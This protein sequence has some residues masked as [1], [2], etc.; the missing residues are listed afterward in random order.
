MVTLLDVG[1]FVPAMSVLENQ[2]RSAAQEAFAA[3]AS[4]RATKPL[5][6]S[7]GSTRSGD[8]EDDCEEVSIHVDG[9]EEVICARARSCSIS[10]PLSGGDDGE[11]DCRRRFDSELERVEQ[12]LRKPVP[13]ILDAVVVHQSVSNEC[14]RDLDAAHNRY[15]VRVACTARLHEELRSQHGQDVLDR[16]K[17]VEE[18]AW[19]ADRAAHRAQA[20]L[21]EFHASASCHALATVELRDLEERVAAWSEDQAAMSRQQ[22]EGLIRATMQAVRCQEDRDEREQAYRL[23]LQRHQHAVQRAEESRQLLGEALARSVEPGLRELRQHQ[24]TLTDEQL[25]ITDLQAKVRSS[26]SAHRRAMEELE[27]IS[28]SVHAAR[29][30][31]STR[32]VRSK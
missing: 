23:A 24:E 15:K 27:R 21:R 1:R 4:L 25:R 2:L 5:V 7:E 9:P 30:Q 32:D 16:A 20:A 8:S 18:A 22:R 6:P 14:Q 10:L 19:L 12:E 11:D 17:P 13:Q 3:E 26:K 31:A 29:T 28:E